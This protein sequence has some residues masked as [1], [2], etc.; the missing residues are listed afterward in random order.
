MTT[1]RD[2][3]VKLRTV[4][5]LLIFPLIAALFAAAAAMSGC[6]GGSGGAAAPVTV[7]KPTGGLI[8]LGTSGTSAS[9]GGIDLQVSLPAGVTVAAD[10]VTGNVASGVVTI[11]GAAAGGSN[12]L[13]AA[14]YTP[15]A[16]GSPAKLH[17]VMVSAAGLPPGEFATI[18]FDLAA[19]A[20]LPAK[21]AFST[22][23]I[24]AKGLDGLTLS[25]VTAVPLSVEATASASAIKQTQAQ[26]VVPGNQPF[27]N[28]SIDTPTRFPSQTITGTLFPGDSLTI[29]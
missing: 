29:S 20:S 24:S 26:V 9:I 8:K 27:L 18:R 13:V 19:G 10:P 4:G 15:A 14:K 1:K 3:P 16:T 28:A 21:D 12:S 17:I 6:S 22:A 5:Q 11:S 2:F 25:G 7:A 23:N